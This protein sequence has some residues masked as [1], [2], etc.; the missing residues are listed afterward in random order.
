MKAGLIKEPNRSKLSDEECRRPREDRVARA[1]IR[2]GR[3]A[4]LKKTAGAFIIFACFF[5]LGKILYNNL[6]EL[7]SYQWG[8][9]P[10]FLALSFLFLFANQTISS[11]AWKRVLL[12]FGA[13]LPLAQ[14]FKIMFV[15]ALGKYLPGKV[16]PYL[17]QMYLSRKAG[18]PRSVTLLSVLM[19]FGISSLVGLLT[20]VASLYLWGSFSA[21]QVSLLLL[22]SLAFILFILSPPV[23]NRLLGALALVSNRFRKGTIPEDVMV[24]GDLWDIAKIISI[25][26]A[27]WVVFGIALYLVSNSFYHLTVSQTIILC[28]VFAVSVISGIVSFLVPAGLG[29]REGVLSYLLSLFIPISAAIVISL[30]LRVWL[31]LGE[32][33]C[34]VAAVRI[35][36]PRLW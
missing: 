19:L 12:L 26:A 13:K 7:N 15:S 36:K 29:V 17:G 33:L 22:G 20:F 5:F 31:I 11:L 21:I 25:F 18:I 14:C 16:W 1:L 3:S 24:R 35:K 9:K 10:S 27:N 4:L 23:L 2:G 32:L 8:L 6:G 28:G 30:V 34:F